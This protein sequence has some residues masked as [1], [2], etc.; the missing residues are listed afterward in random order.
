MLATLNHQAFALLAAPPGLHGAG[1]W[2]A[3]FLAQWPVLAA[4]ATLVLIWVFGL[5][6]ERRAAVAAAVTGF[7]ALA[8][9][10]VSSGLIVSPRPFMDGSATNFLDH[11]PDSSFPSDHC[12]LLFGLAFAFLARPPAR[13]RPLWI[14]FFALALAVGWSRVFLSAHYPLDIVGAALVA[15]AAAACVASRPGKAVTLAITRLGERICP[16]FLI[17][18]AGRGGEAGPIA[19]RSER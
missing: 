9:A 13:C 3:T 17:R 1:L 7:L 5:H 16:S 14:V 10:A 15:G 8:I 12:T 2:A 18:H 6:Q 4:P 11:P 19:T